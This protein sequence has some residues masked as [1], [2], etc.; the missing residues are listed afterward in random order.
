M[1][2]SPA[3]RT[4]MAITL[5]DLTVNIDHLDRETLLEDWVWLIGPSR[6]PILVTASGDA[7]VQDAADGSVHVLDAGAGT[8]ARVAG[9]VD[10]FR[11]LLA[12][13][14]FVADHLAVQ[15]VGDLKQ[16]GVHLA[17]GQLYGFRT[18]PVLGGAYE[19]EN[20][21]P[22][23]IEVHFSTTGQIHEQVRNPPAGNAPRSGA[24]AGPAPAGGS[25]APP[26]R[27][28]LS[29]LGFGR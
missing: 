26:R 23:D 29:R 6:F 17:P 18:P 9:S 8:L 7:F 15:M 19:L 1:I 2:S 12:D 21:E 28:F 22:T 14:D 10:E 13:R 5:Q 11:T 3:R 4:P 25:D 27:S 20:V 16:A 24:P